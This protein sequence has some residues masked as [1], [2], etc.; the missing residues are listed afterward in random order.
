MKYTYEFMTED[1]KAL[2]DLMHDILSEKLDPQIPELDAKGEFPWD[3]Y[4]ELGKAG[5]WAMDVPA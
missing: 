4:N 1:Q 2:V 5:F 3:V